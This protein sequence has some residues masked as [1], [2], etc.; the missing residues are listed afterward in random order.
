MHLGSTSPWMAKLG[1]VLQRRWRNSTRRLTG[2]AG[3]TL[4]EY[5]LIVSFIAVIVL[6]TAL[7]A[8]Q[9]SIASGFAAASDCI[10]GTCVPG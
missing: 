10:S 3:Q 5:G 4:A 7:L 9:G 1:G 8:F 2:Q 6:I